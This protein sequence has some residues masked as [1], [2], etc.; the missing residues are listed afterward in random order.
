MKK[1]DTYINMPI[2]KQSTRMTYF[3]HSLLITFNY[4]NTERDLTKINR[5]LVCTVVHLHTN[6]HICPSFPS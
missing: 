1:Y 5:C 2:M 4:L 6:Y 3:P